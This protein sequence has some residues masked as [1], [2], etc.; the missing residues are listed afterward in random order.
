MQLKE[1]DDPE[2]P[3]ITRQVNRLKHDRK[4][5]QQMCELME[6]LQEKSKKEGRI[7]VFLTA[8]KNGTSLEQLPLLGATEEEIKQCD[9]MLNRNA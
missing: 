1:V 9:E 8:L 4:G 6:K 5:V 2:F 3:E 7:E